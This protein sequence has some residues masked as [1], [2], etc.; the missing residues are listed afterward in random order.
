MWQLYAF[1]QIARISKKIIWFESY[2]FQGVRQRFMSVLLINRK[3]MHGH[4]VYQAVCKTP[5]WLARCILFV[6]HYEAFQSDWIYCVYP[7]YTLPILIRLY[8]VVQPFGKWG[9]DQRN[10]GRTRSVL[11]TASTNIANMAPTW[12][13]SAPDRPHVG[14]MNLAIREYSQYPWL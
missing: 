12:V 10:S 2:L 8:A 13:L 9:A 11:A 4:F 14:P 3:F 7:P 1:W 5:L 6:K